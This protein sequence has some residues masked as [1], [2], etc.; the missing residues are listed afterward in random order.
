MVGS[1][2]KAKKGSVKREQQSASALHSGV[3]PSKARG[4]LQSANVNKSTAKKVRTK[5]NITEEE[6][7]YAVTGQMTE[8][9]E[10]V[11]NNLISANQRDGASMFHNPAYEAKIAK[12]QAQFQDLL[13]QRGQQTN[14]RLSSDD[15]LQMDQFYKVMGEF[16]DN[17][18]C[19]KHASPTRRLMNQ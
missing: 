6:L 2:T 16:Y 8:I 9:E 4:R 14:V 15:P 13:A 12:V 1:I 19:K 18:N 5:V 10:R 3:S 17:T 11:R 7:P